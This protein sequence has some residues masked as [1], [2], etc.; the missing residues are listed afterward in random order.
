MYALQGRIINSFGCAFTSNNIGK[1]QIFFL[2]TEKLLQ[3]TWALLL[4][5]SN[6]VSLINSNDG[7]CMCLSFSQNEGGL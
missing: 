4:N 5:F 2:E 7:N 6:T 3:D 1:E